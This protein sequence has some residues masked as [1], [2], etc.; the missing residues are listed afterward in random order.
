MVMMMVLGFWRIRENYSFLQ[1]DVDCNDQS[2]TIYLASIELDTSA[3]SNNSFYFLITFPNLFLILK[4]TLMMIIA[5]PHICHF[6]STYPIFYK[7]FLHT[8]VRKSRQN[9]SQN[10]VKQTL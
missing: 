2:C 1:S 3:L 7:N 9:G 5:I 8:K 10:S 4:F 6:F